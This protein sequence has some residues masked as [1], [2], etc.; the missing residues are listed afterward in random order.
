MSLGTL[1]FHAGTTLHDGKLQTNGGRVLAS[2][3]VAD[4]LQEAVDDAYEGMQCVS[5]AGKYFRTD[6]GRRCVR[7]FLLSSVWNQY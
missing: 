4:S 5:F 3:A 2:V 7:T 1:L 6:I